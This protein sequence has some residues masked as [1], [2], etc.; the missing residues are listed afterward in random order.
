MKKKLCVL[1]TLCMVAGLFSASVF[2]ASKENIT[3]ELR[4]DFT[5]VIDGKDRTFYS[6]DGQ[7]AQPL[8]YNGT[9][10]LPVRAIGEM[11]GKNVNWDQ[12]SL[13]VTLAGSR[14]TAPVAGTP[15]PDADITK[16]SAEMRPDFTIVIDQSVKNFKDANNEPAYPILYGGTTYLPLRAIG[17]IM[18]KDVGWDH[19][20]KTVTLSGGQSL[21]TDADTFYPSG[22]GQN[23]GNSQ[24]TGS[25]NNTTDIGVEKAKEIALNHAGVSA[26]QATFI[27]TDIDY[28]NGVRVYEVEFFTANGQEYDYEINGATGSIISYDYDAEYYNPNTGSTNG[29]MISEAKAKE[30]ALS[31]VSGATTANIYQFHLDYDDGRVLYEGEIF[32]NQMQYEFE[33]DAY[34]GNIVGWDAESIYS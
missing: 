8:V 2:A 24:N 18:G 21:V 19:T 25:V 31:R 22:T 4:P 27:K 11:M 15:D 20:T 29:T 1:L 14:V 17:E 32:Y 9:T 28:E 5:I 33:I 12:Q 23:T 26:S 16:I 7:E 30:I 3:A 13:T 6:A 10:Y 34:T